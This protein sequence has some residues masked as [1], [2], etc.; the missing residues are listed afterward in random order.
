MTEKAG[1]DAQGIDYFNRGHPLTRL[2]VRFSLRARRRMFDRWRAFARGCPFAA[3]VIDFG[4][5]PDTQRG[6]SNCMIP[7]LLAEGFGVTLYSPEAIGHLA[8]VFPGVRVAVPGS[9]PNLVPLPERSA[10]WVLSSAVL[11]HVGSEERQIA[12]VAECG[13]V[14]DGIFLT[15]PNRGHW[16]EFHTKLPLL[17]WLPKPT[18]RR[19]LR[20]LGHRTWAE[21][22]H[23][24]L[25][26][27]RDLAR[28][29]AR[30]LGR[31][32][33]I[34][35]E[36]QWALGMPSNLVLLARRR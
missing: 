2:Q 35:I 15:T 28:I 18:H 31:A 10:G 36:R 26:T 7:W 17:H 16:L 1:G 20:A 13:R 12:H 32:F 11:E 34:R 30:A 25:V 3:T 5:T 24:N 29:A 21:E 19:I 22:A 4:S 27:R 33:D 6:D 8:D 14:A 23:L 9:D